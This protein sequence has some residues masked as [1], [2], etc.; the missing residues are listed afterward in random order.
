VVDLIARLPGA[1]ID[2]HSEG[3]CVLGLPEPGALTWV[4]AEPG[5]EKPVGKA[6]QD[7]LG[8]G[9]PR[10]GRVL[11]NAQARIAWFGD[12]QALVMGP[13]LK[14][15]AGAAVVDQSDGWLLMR[16]EGAGARDMLMRL[17]PLDLRAASFG[18]GHVARSLAGH[19]PVIVLGRRGG[20][21]DLL[22]PRSM[23]RT[24]HGDLVRAMKTRLAL[25]ALDA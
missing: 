19:V 8:L 5:Q 18:P 6:L 13:A 2:A 10:P 20:A 16:V 22:A 1:E 15:L 24:T 9:W 4:S 7:A 12:R 21:F 23:A 14:S 17:L 25:R 3:D 11:S